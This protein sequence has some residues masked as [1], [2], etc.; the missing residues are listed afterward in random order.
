[1]PEDDGFRALRHVGPETARALREAD[2][3]PAAV[4]DRRVALTDLLAAG[5]NPGVAARLRREYSLAW[6]RHV[7]G[8]DLDRRASAVRGLG[9]AERA[10]IAASAGEWEPG[11]RPAVDA[12]PFQVRESTAE[13]EP[14][15]PVT[16]VDG[17]DAGTAAV[18]ARAG[19]CSIRSLAVADPETVA[20][21]LDLAAEDVRDWRAVASAMREG[22]ERETRSGREE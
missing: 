18:L 19:I 20:D 9:E 22:E 11:E 4:T 16:A 12:F 17:V 14:P 15:T 5:V 1:M 6:S 2:L 13:W 3:E 21:C 7:G 8:D 10:W